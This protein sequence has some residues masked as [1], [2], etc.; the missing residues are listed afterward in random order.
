MQI[1]PQFLLLCHELCEDLICC[2]AFEQVRKEAAKAEAAAAQ[3][4][5]DSDEEVG[6]DDS[7]SGGEL[8]GI[9]GVA[10]SGS[11]AKIGAP[12]AG[13]KR[14]A[15][16]NGDVG[17]QAGQPKQAP[18][19]SGWDLGFLKQNQAR[20]T[21]PHFGRATVRLCM[22]LGPGRMVGSRKG[23]L[24]MMPGQAAWLS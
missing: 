19:A 14:S 21:P 23:A 11:A 20:M 18:D 13:A 4:L 17:S 24:G 8:D 9:K 22:Q 1:T 2:I 16:E 3:P 12:A 15:S 10:C 7:S 5:P 6:D